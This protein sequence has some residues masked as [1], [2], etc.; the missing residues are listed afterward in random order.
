M[1]VSVIGV[2][3]NW[4]R[5]RLVAPLLHIA[6]VLVHVCQH[7]RSATLISPPSMFVNRGNLLAATVNSEL[8]SRIAAR[9]DYWRAIS[10]Y[11]SCPMVRMGGLC[12]FQWVLGAE[13]GEGG[14]GDGA[15]SR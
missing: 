15:A 14:C 13:E 9:C 1:V 6:G 12:V 10:L 8:V 2:A 11:S 7:W 5:E 4:G 3:K